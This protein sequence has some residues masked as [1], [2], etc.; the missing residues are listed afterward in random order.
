MM[1]ISRSFAALL[2][3]GTLTYASTLDV[4]QD[5]SF[6]QYSPATPFIGFTQGI[7]AACD[8]KKT[9]LEPTLACPDDQ[10]LCELSKEIK[11]T[12][13]RLAKIHYNTDA[14][15][16]LTI[17]PKPAAYDAAGAIASARAIGEE[18]ALLERK[19]K[20]TNEALGL[21]GQQFTSQAPSRQPQ[22]LR[23][24]C[25]GELTLAIPRGYISFDNRYEGEISKDKE[26]TVTQYITV[27]NR[28][29]IDIDADRAMFYYRSAHS[30]L[31]PLHFNPWIVSKYI[32]RSKKMLKRS[33]MRAAPMEIA[34]DSMVAEAMP[35]PT[36][37]STSYEDARVYKVNKLMLPSTG[38]P[39]DIRI[40]EW[41][42]LLSCELRAYPYLTT[43]A[44]EVCAFEPKY[45]I[46]KNQWRLK[47]ESRVINENAI[48]EYVHGRYELYTRSDPDIKIGRRPIV[49][50]ERQS[51]IFGGTVREKDGYRLDLTNKSNKSKKLKIIE[52]IPT[53]TTDEI[54]V[55]LL[56]VKSE[57]KMDY[58]VKN[59]GKIEMNVTLKPHEHRTIEIW[60]EIS[61]EKDLKV[62]Y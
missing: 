37:G 32:P 19:A 39:L 13:D 24:V 43:Q 46:E 62:R 33:K 2:C 40:L 57:S 56:E 27:T 60:F 42:A 51:G 41:R 14:L 52:R 36:V 44:V 10:R 47:E 18:R 20:E 21:L 4:Y 31:N 45:Q 6:Y 49:K 22:A 35:I 54:K 8:T 38:E 9:V 26:I 61:H 48:G 25:K 15:K 30:Y 12:E 16:A 53:S 1:L 58:H 23:R 5:K 11:A 55:K 59:D 34:M 29:G 28:S 50:K 7:E 17:L 3:A